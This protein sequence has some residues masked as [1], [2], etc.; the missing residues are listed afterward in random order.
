MPDLT[1]SYRKSLDFIVFSRY[2]DIETQGH[3]D[4]YE[5]RDIGTDGHKNKNMEGRNIKS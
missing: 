3:W 2:N 4:A 1:V 5:H